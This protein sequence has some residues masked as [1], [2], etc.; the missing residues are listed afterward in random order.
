VQ[1]QLFILISDKL[2][3]VPFALNTAQ[4]YKIFLQKN[5]RLYYFRKAISKLLIAEFEKIAN[6]LSFYKNVN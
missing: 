5:K 2:A 1:S 4:I 3:N 6:V